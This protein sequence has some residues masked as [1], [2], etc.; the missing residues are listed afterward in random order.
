MSLPHPS[1][2]FPELADDKL[3]TIASMLIEEHEATEDDLRRNTDSGYTRGTTRFGRQKERLI[4]EAQSSKY[5]WLRLISTTND[6]VFSIA[7][8]PFRFSFDIASSPS[9]PAVTEVSRYQADFFENSDA[10]RPARQCFILD[11]SL[12]NGNEAI[13][14]VQF[15][16]A[17]GTLISRWSSFAPAR[18][19]VVH[20]DTLPDAVQL[21]KPTIKPKHKD[22]GSSDD[23]VT[24]AT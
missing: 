7:G 23:L 14:F 3:Q 21:S 10:N 18:N 8:I 5:P 12:T 11:T 6:L 13:V 16:A 4:R 22:S 20:R 2:Y 9:K 17:A 1:F 15:Y 19:V 24:A